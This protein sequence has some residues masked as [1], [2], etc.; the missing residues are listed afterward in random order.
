MRRGHRLGGA[1]QLACGASPRL[2]DWELPQ[3]PEKGGYLVI[4]GTRRLELPIHVCG[5]FAATR[6]RTRSGPFRAGLL[7]LT[8]VTPRSIPV[9]S[10][11]RNLLGCLS[12]DLYLD[13]DT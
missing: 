1:G 3:G 7:E 8:G 9:D 6:P 10:L 13:W 4:L 2:M 5:V 11:V 12:T